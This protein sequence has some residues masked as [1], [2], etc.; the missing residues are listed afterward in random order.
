M[1]SQVKPMHNSSKAQQNRTWVQTAESIATF[2]IETRLQIHVLCTQQTW[3]WATDTLSST[4][5]TQNQQRQASRVLLNGQWWGI[6]KNALSCYSPKGSPCM[7]SNRASHVLPRSRFGSSLHRMWSS[8][9]PESTVER[10]LN[11]IQHNPFYKSILEYQEETLIGIIPRQY[12]DLHHEIIHSIGL[13][14]FS[15]V[16]QDLVLSKSAVA[17]MMKEKM[18]TELL[19]MPGGWFC[20]C[21][22]KMYRP[23][24]HSDFQ[25]KIQTVL[26]Y[27]NKFEP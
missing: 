18:L 16:Y 19:G 11:L 8:T 9:S 22:G 26:K 5:A 1:S 21:K 2:Q 6:W 24:N 10:V 14:T 15:S 27:S 17:E 23:T 12:N 4:V 25:V 7:H 13:W 20:S 3:K